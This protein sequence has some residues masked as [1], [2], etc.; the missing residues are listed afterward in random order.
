MITLEKSD[1]YK[2]CSG[3]NSSTAVSYKESSQL[4]WRPWATAG[5]TP[6]STRVHGALLCWGWSL[7]GVDLQRAVAGPQCQEVRKWAVS[8][9]NLWQSAA[10]TGW[11]IISGTVHRPAR[12]W[13]NFPRVTLVQAE[14]QSCAAR[15]WW[16]LKIP[17]FVNHNSK[18]CKNQRI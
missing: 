13:I 14:D 3:H 11:G 8:F 1:T 4:K 7:P 5:P 18:K 12:A 9:R 10:G 2:T 17:R 6:D 15:P 16:H